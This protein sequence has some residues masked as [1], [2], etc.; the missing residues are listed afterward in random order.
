MLR[1]DHNEWP[2]R[3]LRPNSQYLTGSTVGLVSASQVG[4]KVIELLRPFDT[5]VLV[6][7]PYLTEQEAKNLR[8]KKVTLM[9]IFSQSDIVSVHAPLLPNTKSMINRTHFTVLKEGAVFI[10]TS[11]GGVL[12]EQALISELETG[13][14]SAALDV[15]IE[16]PLPKDSLLLSLKN[17]VVTPH[18]AGSGFYGYAKIGESAVR[19]L[20]DFFA[21]KPVD[22]A[23]DFEKYEIIA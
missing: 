21:G 15:S 12:D 7:D 13:R 16:E 20:E 8:V 2:D 4:R 9:D 18:L 3:M 22:G 11:R 1:N 14:I 5:T 23:V 17:V 6:F 10:N 19:A